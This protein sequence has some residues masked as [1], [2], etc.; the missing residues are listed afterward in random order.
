MV[1]AKLHSQLHVDGQVDWRAIRTGQMLVEP[2]QLPE[3]VEAKIRVFM[4]QLGIVFGSFDFIVTPDGDYVFLEVNEQGQFLWLEEYNSNFHML[5]IFIQFLLHKSIDYHWQS[6]SSPH[7]INTYRA[8][9]TPILNENM[10]RH[11][12]LNRADM[13]QVPGAL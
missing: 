13:C 2:Y 8:K 5:D 7:Q 12:D 11:V 10:Q 1:A 9:I 6:S 4:R 3:D